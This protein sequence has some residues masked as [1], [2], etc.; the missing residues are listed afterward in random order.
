MKMVPGMP[1]M[2]GRPIVMRSVACYNCALS[3]IAT[4]ECRWDIIS[5][6]RRRTIVSGWM[7][8]RQVEGDYNYGKNE[9]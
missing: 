3:L 5:E 7:K 1:C 6:E 8:R 4:H 2:A 9:L